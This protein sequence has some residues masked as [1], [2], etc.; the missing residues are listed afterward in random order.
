MNPSSENN[1][2]PSHFKGKDAIE[3]VAEAQAR[4]II[5]SAEIHGTETSGKVAAATD[6][7]RDSALVL[8]LVAQIFALMAWP[9]Q[10][11][12][13]LLG[14]VGFALLLWKA[15]RSAWLGWSRLER[16]HRV[17]VQEKWEIDHNRQQERDELRALYAAKGLDGKLLEDVLDVLM[18]DGDRL[19]KVMVQEELGLSLATYDHPLMQSVGAALGVIAAI[20]LA[21]VGATLDGVWGSIGAALLMIGFS[22]GLAAYFADNRIVPAVVWNLGLAALALATLHFLLHYFFQLPL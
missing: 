11:V 13:L 16:L 19:L 20:A 22:A 5:D 21:L 12:F 15:G 4:G 1:T 3:H 18:A 9:Q 14:I 10:S 8:A 7:A 6:A 17:L 2:Q